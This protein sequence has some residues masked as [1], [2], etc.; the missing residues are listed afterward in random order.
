MVVCADPASASAGGA[1]AAFARAGGWARDVR[2]GNVERQLSQG[3]A[4]CGLLRAE[5]PCVPGLPLWGEDRLRG[6]RGP[7]V[8]TEAR[9]YL[10][11]ASR[12][13]LGDEAR[14]SEE[15]EVGYR[16]VVPAPRSVARVPTAGRSR[17]RNSSRSTA[18]T[19]PR[20][21]TAGGGGTE[22]QQRRGA[23]VIARA[24]RRRYR[25]RASTPA[26]SS[27]FLPSPAGGRGVGG[28]RDG[29]GHGSRRGR[30]DAG[31]Q[32]GT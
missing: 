19:G 10:F 30:R 12:S 23:H 8:G 11:S 25:V 6:L 32:G 15:R 26:P 2:D 17:S 28:A 21:G 4:S 22:R 27:A 16:I 9:R 20:F 24:V 7:A 3:S 5:P 13:C 31:R 18:A 14:R 1:G 29:R